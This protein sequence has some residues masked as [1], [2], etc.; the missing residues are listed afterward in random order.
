MKR[1]M[2]LRHAK[3]A[4]PDADDFAR[5]LAPLGREDMRLIAAILAE[6]GH[7]PDLALVSPAARTRET[8]DAAGLADVP[9]RF[10]PAIYG[11][12]AD[13]LLDLVRSTDAEVETL[14]VVGHNPGIEDLAHWLVAA[15]CD[16]PEDA[17]FRAGMPTAAL[18][19]LGLPVARW[20]ETLPETGRL[21]RF[22]TPAMLGGGGD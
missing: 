19:V 15:G 22:V 17:L 9:V 18:A 12:A 8:W 6:P 13:T 21:D 14:L 4:P 16:G 11:G 10:R 20:S 7:R 5:P 1:L 2:L 3:A